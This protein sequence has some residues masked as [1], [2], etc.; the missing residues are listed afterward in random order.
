MGSPCE[1]QFYAEGDAQ[2]QTVVHAAVNDILRLESKYS[3]YKNDS[4]LSEINRSAALG[5]S[6]DVDPETAKLLDYAV[7]CYQQSHGLFDIT[8][9]GLR[10]LW[11]FNQDNPGIPGPQEIEAVLSSVGW[12]KINWIA[13]TLNFRIAGL[14]LDFGGI[15]KEYAADRVAS[16]CRV[17][18]VEH[19][20][21]NLGGDIK[22]IGCH[23]DQSPWRIGIRDPNHEN[24]VSGVV[25]LKSG[26][27]ATSGD[28]ERYWLIDGQRYSHILNP[29]TGWP[30]RHFAS[31][32]VVSEHCVLA[33]SA[34]TIAMLQEGEGIAWLNALGLPYQSIDSHGVIAGT[35]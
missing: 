35:L 14:E 24:S 23:P 1:L 26:A 34:S 15:V 6:I 12:D 2:F 31:I 29:K 17:L 28:Y 32:T 22:I 7:T 11:R 27:M 9:G 13:P 30:V 25:F 5:Q 19:G 8:S 33:G 20:I 18:G 10:K 4:L 16:L 21:I 3:R